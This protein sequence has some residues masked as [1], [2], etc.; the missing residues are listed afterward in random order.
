MIKKITINSWNQIKQI[1]KLLETKKFAAVVQTDTVMGLVSLNP[2]LIYEIKQ[3][4]CNKKLI[5]FVSNINQV[6]K[7][8]QHEKNVISR[9]WPGGLTI[10]KNGVS[11][12][13]P[14]DKHLLS[15]I[16]LTGPLY[17]SSANISGNNPITDATQATKEFNKSLNKLLIVK[18][19]TKSN[20]PST[21]ID[22]DSFKIIREGVYQGNAIMKQ[23]KPLIYIGADHAG[24]LMKQQII[25]KLSNKYNFKDLGTDNNIKSVD[26]PIYAFKV[27]DAVAKDTN[28]I[29]ILVCGT[30]YGMCIAANKVKGIRAICL[31]DHKLASLAKEHNNCNVITLSGRFNKLENN[32]KIINNF[33]KAKFDTKDPKNIR[34]VE[35][36][37]LITKRENK[38]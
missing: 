38:C 21:I 20:I 30:G 31:Y 24:F 7:L 4:P 11:Y 23:L 25:A 37:K 34:H 3:R 17:S 12:R 8:N 5:F 18:G 1:A 36:I 15:L 33:M 10:I 26:Y 29:G 2:K 6:K 35:R 16:K 27:G 9:Y 13:M 19:K 32:I 28:A 14:N 22:L